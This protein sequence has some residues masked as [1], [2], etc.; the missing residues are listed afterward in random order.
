MP[1]PPLPRLRL[2]HIHLPTPGPTPSS[3]PP[4]ALA[5]RLQSHLRRRLLDFKDDPT[6][7]SAQPL[8]TLVSFSPLPIFTLG[9]RQTAPLTQKEQERLQSPLHFGSNGISLPVRTLHSPRGG[10][11]T[12]HG[13]GQIVLWP[14]V[15][16]K[17]KVQSTKQFTVRCYSRLLEQATVSTLE[18]LFGIKAGWNDENPGVWVGDGVLKEEKKIAALGVHLRRYVSGLGTAIN[19]DMDGSS[20]S[21]SEEEEDEGRTNP[22]KRVV[23]CG[24][25]GK[26]VTSVREV[27]GSREKLDELL[28]MMDGEEK[29]KT[30]EE[31]VADA[32]AKEFAE[33]IGIEGGEVE[34]VKEGEI[35]Q[36]LSRLLEEENEGCEQGEGT[37]EEME[38]FELL[39]K[40][41]VKT[42]RPKFTY[43]AVFNAMCVCTYLSQPPTGAAV[44]RILPAAAAATAAAAAAA[45]AAVTQPSPHIP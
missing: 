9:R 23:A 3:S 5:S 29:T 6:S 21:S 24:L 33:R 18:K 35:V 8:P 28:G 16:L 10:L 11:T 30:R 4:Y 45:A 19:V 42:C 39:K 34:R 2:R 32:W 25:E 14:I 1:P 27:L 26:E 15:D 20:S 41:G 38:Y 17:S 37:E 40:R 22:W 43:R 12:Y 13:P 36:V 31:K 44:E 7:F